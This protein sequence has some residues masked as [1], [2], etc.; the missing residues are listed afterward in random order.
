MANRDLL[1]I[2]ALRALKEAIKE[3]IEDHKRSGRPL[4]IWRNGKT[5][6]V[7]AAK[8]LHKHG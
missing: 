8:L 4:I 6:K 5:A 1:Q 3:V 2:K 7:P